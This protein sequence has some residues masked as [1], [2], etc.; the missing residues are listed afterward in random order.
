MEASCNLYLRR[1]YDLFPKQFSSERG[2]ITQN[3]TCLKTKEK[4]HCNINEY[5]Q[6]ERPEREINIEGCLV[7]SMLDEIIYH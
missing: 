6:S 7:G 1:N 2:K 3:E 4:N 5:S